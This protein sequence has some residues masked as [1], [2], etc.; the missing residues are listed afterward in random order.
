MKFYQGLLPSKIWDPVSK[1]IVADFSPNKGFIETSDKKL[2]ALLKEKGYPTERDMQ[3][4]ERTGTSPHGGFVQAAKEGSDLPSGRPSVEQP[5]AA[6][7]NIR[8]AP[9]KKSRVIPDEEPDL[10]DAEEVIIKRPR[11]STAKKKA[12]KKR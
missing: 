10:S 12:S 6:A 9:V 1:S 7:A 4:Y 8:H 5:G 2:I 11:R 3:Y